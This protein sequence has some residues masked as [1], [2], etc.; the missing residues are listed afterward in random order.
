MES[1]SGRGVEL[2]RWKAETYEIAP[3][4]KE[5]EIIYTPGYLHPSLRVATRLPRGLAEYGDSGKLFWKIVDLFRDHIG[6]CAR[7][8]RGHYPV[9]L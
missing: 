2:L 7:A 1:R 9:C 3:Q 5:G 6:L 8:W 4:F